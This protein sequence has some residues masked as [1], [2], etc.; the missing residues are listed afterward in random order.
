MTARGRSA[1]L[2]IEW[3]FA[4]LNVPDRFERNTD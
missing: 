1:T 3:R 4:A 2:Q